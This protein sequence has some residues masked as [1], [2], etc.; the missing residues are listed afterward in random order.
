MENKLKFPAKLG[1]NNPNDYGVID[2]VEIS[3][4]RCVANLAALYAL[5]DCVLSSSKDNTGDDAIG[6]EWY[7][8][9]EHK[10]YQLVSWADRASSAGWTISSVSM[11]MIYKGSVTD[12]TDLPATLTAN[13]IGFVYNI[14]NGFTI[15]SGTFAGTYPAGTD[16]AWTGTEWNPLGGNKYTLSNADTYNR[17]VLEDTTGG[18]S[19]AL[20]LNLRNGE[21]RCS[22]VGLTDIYT[23]PTCNAQQSI[24]FGQ[25]SEITNDLGG[26]CFA[27][28][29]T[30]HITSSFG[31]G[32][33][34]S[35]DVNGDWAFGGG[36]ISHANGNGSFCY[37]SAYSYTNGE[38]DVCFGAFNTTSKTSGL[39][40]FGAAIGI[41]NVTTNYG[42]TTLGVGN[43]SLYTA[44]DMS[45]TTAFTIGGG[46]IR[47]AGYIDSDPSVNNGRTFN[48]NPC[49]LFDVR[50]NGDIYLKSN[51]TDI[52][53]DHY[54]AEDDGVAASTHND[55]ATA[56]L[57]LQGSIQQNV[58]YI[59]NHRLNATVANKVYLCT[60]ERKLVSLID[61]V[62]VDLEPCV[63]NRLYCVTS[64]RTIYKYTEDLEL[65]KFNSIIESNDA[66]GRL[67]I[68]NDTLYNDGKQKI[69]LNLNAKNGSGNHSIILG[70]GDGDFDSTATGVYS[71]K[72]STSVA[73]A[74]YALSLGWYC[75][76]PYG[77]NG[78][79]ALGYNSTSANA[80]VSVAI[81]N[82]THAMGIADVSIGRCNITSSDTYTVNNTANGNRYGYAF[83]AYLKTMSDAESAIGFCNNPLADSSDNALRTAFTVGGGIIR[84]SVYDGMNTSTDLVSETDLIRLNLFDVRRNG[85]VYIKSNTTDI[86]ADTASGDDFTNYLNNTTSADLCLQESVHQTIEAKVATTASVTTA[87]KIYLVEA[88]NNLYELVLSVPT[89]IEPVVKNRIYVCESDGSMWRYNG[90]T[91]V[92]LNASGGG[93][94]ATDGTTLQ[95]DGSQA[96][97]YAIKP[98]TETLSASDPQRILTTTYN[99]NTGQNEIAWAADSHPG[100]CNFGMLFIKYYG[101]L[102]GPN[103]HNDGTTQYIAT[104]FS[105]T[106][107]VTFKKA[108]IMIT[109]SFG[110]GVIHIAIYKKDGNT[111]PLLATASFTGTN[112]NAGLV[113]ASFDTLVELDPTK[114]YYIMFLDK[115]N[116]GS[117]GINQFD[118][119]QVSNAGFEL[120][121]GQ[122]SGAT[123][124]TFPPSTLPTNYPYPSNSQSQTKYVPWMKLITV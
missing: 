85:D 23:A 75:G 51:T 95:G 28:G 10:F 64:D 25:F 107:N 119:Q 76:V 124:N 53:T 24:C 46:K 4:H 105:P 45:Q 21:G 73:I 86:V 79:I 111:N 42:E 50:R 87:D 102:V 30:V 52:T 97:P 118:Y 43:I 27:F 106:V 34:R 104:A 17:L 112:L 47:N 40:N 90:S 74:N 122:T 115:G 65:I 16:V 41:Y 121:Y 9:S 39:G 54:P 29:R 7:V 101:S 33:G 81:G 92:Q 82:L 55:I 93:G 103:N 123:F 1:S 113:T 91:Y 77:A 13:D 80:K 84:T 120:G 70:Y 19:I 110:S 68:N 67:V 78:A 108:Q 44:N 31:F 58:D 20:D 8:I 88:D 38:G 32:I 60:N 6:Q 62:V 5:K 36:N 69:A 22:L 83:G 96:T 11:Y 49:N 109:Q 116:G 71:I 18:Q 12:Y 57:L 89:I 56:N 98:T 14:I 117:Y 37:G 61:G 94:G 48:A 3:G 2:A 26:H 72:S 15:S 100:Y 59:T 99:T 35:V 63:V 114:L 66:Y